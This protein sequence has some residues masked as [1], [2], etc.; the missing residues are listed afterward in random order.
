MQGILTEFKPKMNGNTHEMYEK[1]YKFTVKLDSNGKIIEGE[2]MAGRTEGSR[3]WMIGKAHNFESK[4]NSY[5]TGGYSIRGLKVLEELTNTNTTSTPASTK[6][7]YTQYSVEKEAWTTAR[8]AHNLAV[9]YLNT[10]PE[11]EVNQL[12]SDH[13]TDLVGKMAKSIFNST[14]ELAESMINANAGGNS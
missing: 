4:E 3:A 10:L 1:Y 9:E 8:Y 5:A 6:S 2:A 14:K 12:R 11:D 7:Y 13:K